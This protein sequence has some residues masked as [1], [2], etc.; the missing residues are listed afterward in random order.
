MSLKYLPCL[1]CGRNMGV[2]PED[3]P[4]TTC[5]CWVCES[6]WTAKELR[7]G[8]TAAEYEREAL[9]NASR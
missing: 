6:Q 9:E 1:H 3:G 5:T 8:M 4:D 7:T 2:D